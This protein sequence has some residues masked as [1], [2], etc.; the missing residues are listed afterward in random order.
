MNAVRD[1][2]VAVAPTVR[3]TTF[4]DVQGLLSGCLL[5]ALGVLMLRHAGL[6]SGG[7]AGL[8]ILIHYRTHWPLGA[9][10][11]VVNLPFYVFG[12]K[13]LGR[14]FTFK[15]FAA[16]SL[17]SVFVAALPD[18][19]SFERLDPVFA[20]VAAG[21]LCGSGILMLIRHG[22][23][24]GGIG[25][26]AIWLQKTRGWRAGTVQMVCDGAILVTAFGVVAPTKILWSLLGAAVLNLVIGVNHRTDRYFGG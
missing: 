24:L 26:L 25:I 3:H 10:L 4:D 14:T 6:A 21:L 9:V 12:W 1:P 11:F 15:T 16:V 22:A 17:L 18:V 2:A 8:S 5:V 20:A 19:L 13:A 23:S 7:T